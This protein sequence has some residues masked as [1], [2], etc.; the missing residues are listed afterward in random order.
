VY[1][2]Q[3]FLGGIASATLLL[4]GPAT[5]A[6]AQ[7]ADGSPLTNL[8]Q[9]L[10]GSQVTASACNLGGIPMAGQVNSAVTAATGQS[11]GQSGTSQD[12]QQSSGNNSP[13][14]LTS[15][16]SALPGL[17]TVTGEIPGLSSMS[18]SL[19]DLSAP[20]S[21]D[22]SLAA[23]QTAP[24]TTPMQAAD[25]PSLG[26]PQNSLGSDQ[27]SANSDPSMANN[28]V[29]PGAL[30]GVTGALPVG[31]LTNGLPDLG[32]VTGTLTGNS[33]PQS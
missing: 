9:G 29:L 5:S 14:S 2:W 12:P 17:S 23:N 7:T 24:V 13:A 16:T 27:S 8:A 28:S 32:S 25:T 26:S 31:G 15:M 3:V 1:K 20:A 21:Q 22:S 30:T 4:A 6:L 11:C 19:P 18:S 33:A 10:T